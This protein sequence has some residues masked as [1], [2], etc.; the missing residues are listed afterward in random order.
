MN[1]GAE[2][3]NSKFPIGTTV[4]YRPILDELGGFET[5]TRSIAWRLG[6]GAS[7]VQIKGRTG[8]VLLEA[9]EVLS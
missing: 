8:S 1:I 4:F 6:H 5:V 7:V 9:I 3:F 2:E